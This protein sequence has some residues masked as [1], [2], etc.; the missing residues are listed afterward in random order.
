MWNAPIPIRSGRFAARSRN[1]SIDPGDNGATLS[2]LPAMGEWL[3]T[4]DRLSVFIV[5]L[6]FGGV[7]GYLIAKTNRAFRDLNAT[8][9]AVGVLRKAAWTAAI[10]AVG[11]LAIAMTPLGQAL[12]Q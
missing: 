10:A 3:A 8:M 11:W 12:R 1:T 4:G 9:K 2:N 7:T 5:G 6:M